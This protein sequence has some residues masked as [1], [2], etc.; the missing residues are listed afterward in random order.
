MTSAIK[1][2]LSFFSTDMEKSDTSFFTVLA[3]VL[4]GT[5]FATGTVFVNSLRGED[6]AAVPSSTTAQQENYENSSSVQ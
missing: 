3:W 1:I 5:V 4:A 6:G 2:V